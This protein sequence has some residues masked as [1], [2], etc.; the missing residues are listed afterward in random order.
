MSGIESLVFAA[1]WFKP[2]KLLFS[3]FDGAF[4]D[5]SVVHLQRLIVELRVRCDGI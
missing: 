3:K 5:L 2:D 1:D 4:D